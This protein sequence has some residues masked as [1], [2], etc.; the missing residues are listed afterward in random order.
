MINVGEDYFLQSKIISAWLQGTHIKNS[1][2]NKLLIMTF[3]QTLKK[4]LKDTGTLY[5]R[6]W[7][8]KRNKAEDITEIKMLH[9]PKEYE[10]MNPNRQLYT[11]QELFDIIDDYKNKKDETNR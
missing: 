4:Q 1:H 3:R 5:D 10:K 9:D 2:Y 6:R 11:D 7:F 8:I